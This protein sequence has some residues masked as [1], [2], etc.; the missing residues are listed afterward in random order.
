[1]VMVRAL[2]TLIFLKVFFVRDPVPWTHSGLIRR[3]LFG[4]LFGLL[5]VWIISSIGNSFIDINLVL[6]FKN[7]VLGISISTVIG[8]VSGFFPAYFASQLNPID[9]I[10]K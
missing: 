5:I 2:F 4:G 1:M 9:A 7:I 8:I 10:R 3:S 6:T